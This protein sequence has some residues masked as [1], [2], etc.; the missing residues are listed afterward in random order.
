MIVMKDIF[1]NLKFRYE[2]IV[3]VF[4]GFNYHEFNFAII[5]SHIHLGE[6]NWRIISYLEMY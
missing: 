2:S 6:K 1:T 4:F 5:N 3:Y